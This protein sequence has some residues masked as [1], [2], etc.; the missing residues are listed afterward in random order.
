MADSLAQLEQRLRWAKQNLDGFEA[1]AKA[2]ADRVRQHLAL[3]ETGLAEHKAA[4]GNQDPDDVGAPPPDPPP[5]PP[6]PP[7]AGLTVTIAL[8]SDGEYDLS[9]DS[10]TAQVDWRYLLGDGTPFVTPDPRREGTT[11]RRDL[12]GW[13][14]SGVVTIH[15]TEVGGQARTGS[16]SIDLGTP[17]PP[18]PPPPTPLAAPQNVRQ[19]T[20]P[21]GTTQVEF[22]P[23]PGADSHQYE[24]R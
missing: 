13:G 3:L 4:F 12:V 10:Q 21:D 17:Q 14:G 7:V 20:A 11:T 22:D 6:P 19:S 2:R 23:V 24:V 18:A 8:R 9:C 1:D 15:A 16:A 5:P